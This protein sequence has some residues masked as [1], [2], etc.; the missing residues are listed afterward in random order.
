MCVEYGV[1]TGTFIGPLPLTRGEWAAR[2]ARSCAAGEFLMPDDGLLP[3]PCIAFL[4]SPLGFSH[5]SDCSGPDRAG[6][7]THWTLWKFV[8]GRAPPAFER[9]NQLKLNAR[10]IRSHSHPW[11]CHAKDLDR[12]RCCSRLFARSLCRR[13]QR[14]EPL[15]E[16]SLQAQHSAKSSFKIYSGKRTCTQT[17]LNRLIDRQRDL[18]KLKLS[19]RSERV[20]GKSEDKAQQLR[21]HCYVWYTLASWLHGEYCKHATSLITNR[22]ETLRIGIIMV[23]S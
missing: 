15:I 7:I 14:Y 12:C 8:N 20:C 13:R 10:P 16:Y 9:V 1:W 4:L 5:A 17:Q 23:Y 22:N 2:N 11:L 18:P 19:T 21:F 6:P 3:L